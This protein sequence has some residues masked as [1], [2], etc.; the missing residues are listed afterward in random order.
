MTVAAGAT[1]PVYTVAH[2]GTDSTAT[3]VELSS[4]DS[5]SLYT[6]VLSSLSAAGESDKS[7]AMSVST[8]PG[9]A[10][11]LLSTLQTTSSISLA[12]TAP[13]DSERRG[14]DR[15]QGV[16]RSYFHGVGAYEVGDGYEQV[17]DL[18]RLVYDGRVRRDHGHRSVATELNDLEGGSLYTYLVGV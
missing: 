1:E 8:A 2:D 6:Y 12:W 18:T 16:Q 5:G 10:T 9:V 13:T 15:L 4:L 14:C 3:S 11:G 17:F 7:D